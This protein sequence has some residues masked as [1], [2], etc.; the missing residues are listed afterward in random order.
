MRGRRILSERPELLRADEPKNILIF[1][2]KNCIF[3]FNFN[4]AG[5]FADY[6]LDAPEGTY[7][8]VLSSDEGRFGGFDRIRPGESHTAEG[9]EL[10]LYLPSRAALVF[11][12]KS[13]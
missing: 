4:P 1:K 10:R 8:L 13:K 7:V 5:S 12:M 6:G 9:G 11:E 3:A 2:R